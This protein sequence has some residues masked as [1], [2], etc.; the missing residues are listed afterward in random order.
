MPFIQFIVVS[1]AFSVVAYRRAKDNGARPLLWAFIAPASYLLVFA[2]VQIGIGA[3][4]YATARPDLLDD[5]RI[6][7]VIPLVVAVVATWVVI[8]P[9]NRKSTSAE[10]TS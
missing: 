5:W 8:M 10:P 7:T 2:L 3:I 9:L 1:V 6:V 4:L